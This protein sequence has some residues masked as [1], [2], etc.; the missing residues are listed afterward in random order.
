[1]KK[2]KQDREQA[3]LEA[4]HKEFEARG[5]SEED[6]DDFLEEGEPEKPL[7]QTPPQVIKA[8]GFDPLDEPDKDFHADGTGEDPEDK[9]TPKKKTAAKPKSKLSR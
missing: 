3:Y 4:M 8:L 2:T 1:M 6:W 9:A 7:L 5:F